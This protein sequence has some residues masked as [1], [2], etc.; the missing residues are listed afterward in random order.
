MLP[1]TALITVGPDFANTLG[2]LH[3]AR[4]PVCFHQR[5]YFYGSPESRTRFRDR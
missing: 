5:M 3:Y 4:I 2:A 1:D